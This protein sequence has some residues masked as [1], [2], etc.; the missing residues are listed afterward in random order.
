MPLLVVRSSQ[1]L[2]EFVS[3]KRRLFELIEALVAGVEGLDVF[4]E[5]SLLVRNRHRANQNGMA[6]AEIHWFC[7]KVQK[8][9]R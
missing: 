5:P 7:M 2:E 4:G 6:A 8:Q 3:S 1:K 9:G